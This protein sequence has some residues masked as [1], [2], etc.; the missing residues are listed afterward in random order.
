MLWLS[1]SVSTAWG[2][3]SF[4]SKSWIWLSAGHPKM[5]YL[6]SNKWKKPASLLQCWIQSVKL[7]EHVM[8]TNSN[9]QS[10]FKH[11]VTIDRK[12]SSSQKQS[13]FIF[14]Y[15]QKTDS[16]LQLKCFTMVYTLRLN[17]AQSLCCSEWSSV[18]MQRVN[19]HTF[20]RL[21]SMT[22]VRPA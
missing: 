20:S 7:V 12:Q 13:V 4:C 3:A 5:H 9:Q 18:L 1:L 15:Q 16:S 14:F 11:S 8:V 6:H 22:R 10:K 21:Y 19:V 2:W 17:R